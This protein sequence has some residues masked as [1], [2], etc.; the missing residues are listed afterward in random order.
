MLWADFS[1]KGG[2]V[3]SYSTKKLKTRRNAGQTKEQDNYPLLSGSLINPRRRGRA[4]GY[5]GE[6]NDIPQKAG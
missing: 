2:E 6:K 4:G 1:R 3:T 5:M